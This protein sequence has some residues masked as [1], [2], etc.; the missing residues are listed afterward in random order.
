MPVVMMN[1][2]TRCGS[3]LL[4]QM[5][6]LVPGT[7]AM[8][9]CWAMVNIHQLRAEG[10]ISREESLEM[11]R[12]AVRLHCKVSPGEKVENIFMKMT[13]TNSPIFPD[14]MDIFP[15]FTYIFNT[16][17][18]VPMLISSKKMNDTILKGNWY[19]ILGFGWRFRKAH[20]FTF[21]Y[22]E[23]YDKLL[24]SF[25]SW[26]PHVDDDEFGII[27]I[28]GVIAEFFDNKS[29]YND[30]I[31]YEDLSVK[32]E[33]ELKKIFKALHISEDHL[34]LALQAMN[35]DSQKGQYG[36]VR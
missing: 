25:S 15:N 26:W 12:S 4:V 5:M 27:W 1:M 36:K 11:I 18:P 17:H 2:T 16:R 8:S 14:I 22:S 29:R 7:R 30:V 24:S 3:T 10:R 13:P 28:S 19:E 21:P 9:E 34:S 20:R 35:K 33:Q 32:P 6:N 31:L 23:K